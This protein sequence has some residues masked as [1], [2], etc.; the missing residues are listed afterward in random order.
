[1]TAPLASGDKGRSTVALDYRNYP[2][3]VVDDEPDILRAFRFNYDD[4]FEVLT[5]EG[6]AEGLALITEHRPAVIVSDQ[7]MPSMSG[8]EFLSRSMEIHP[9]AMRIVLTGYTDMDALVEAVNESHIYRYV[10]KPWDTDEMRLT[11][12]RA[13]EVFDLTA[14]NKRLV[15]EL[16]HLNERL[17]DENAY[18]REA[19]V[20]W[21]SEIVGTSP[22]IRRVLEMVEKVGPQPTTVLVL[23]ETGTGK[24]L[25]ARAIHAT[26]E[27][28]DKLFVGVNCAELSAGVLESELFGH[29]KGAFTGADGDRKGLFEVADGG[30]LFLDEIS[31]TTRDLQGK[32]LRALQEGEIRPVGESQPRKV[33]VRVVVATNRDLKGEVK[34]GKFREDLFYRV[35][36]F[37]IEVPPLRE[38][39]EDV[40]LLTEHFV[41]RLSSQLKKRIG[42]PTPET[43]AI[44]SRYQFPGNVR[45]LANEIERAIILAE[46][47][48]PLSEDL[49]SEH[50]KAAGAGDAPPGTLQRRTDDFEREQI[51]RTIDE[52][53]GVKTRA[54][55]ALGI[56]Y[57]G[58]LK[59]MRRLGM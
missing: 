20:S 44:L 59:K 3:L 30:T 50:V 24:E 18:L 55:E 28:R 41:R 25:V 14:E 29:R 42:D 35:N 13:I 10:T 53:E 9:D 49:L 8:T 51:R 37:P 45:E 54:A 26:S 5:A 58:L 19:T 43:L 2:I 17:A 46:P 39:T 23:G 47:G 57:R 48:G 40:A 16:Q 7:R 21:A 31:E 4:E 34:A 33:D 22:A 1:L 56:T 11:L 12:R 15:K 6:G 27:R 38:R 36:A 32:L 52:C